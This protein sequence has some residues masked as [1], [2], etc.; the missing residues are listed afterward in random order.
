[1]SDRVCNFNAGPATLPLPVLERAKNDLPNFGISFCQR[2][3]FI[4]E[5]GIYFG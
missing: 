4:K 5:Y 1:M 3:C 2:A